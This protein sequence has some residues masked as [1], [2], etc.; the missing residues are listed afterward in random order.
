MSEPI[1]LISA[2][3]LKALCGAKMGDPGFGS[4]LV[5]G[6][7]AAT[8][9]DANCEGCLQAAAPTPPPSPRPVREGETLGR[10]GRVGPKGGPV[11]VERARDM[12]PEDHR[13]A[14]VEVVGF[15]DPRLI[16]TSQ[17][18][19]AD[20]KGA[21]L[22]VVGVDDHRG[23]QHLD[24]KGEP[25]PSEAWERANSDLRAGRFDSEREAMTRDLRR[26]REATP[27]PQRLEHVMQ[28]VLRL[29]STR[30]AQIRETDAKSGADNDATHPNGGR[31]GDLAHLAPH[32][33]D[34]H[35]LSIRLHVEWVEDA[36]D[37]HHGRSTKS[38]VLMSSEEKDALLTGSKL[39]GLSPEEIIAVHPELGAAKTIRYVRGLA[40]Q[41]ARGLPKIDRQ[42]AA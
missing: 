31:H 10:A 23:L 28:E 17:P 4:A 19:L 27:L 1:H 2:T 7:G 29:Q 32:E 21:P 3:T 40:G 12:S 30:A 15:E 33:L 5:H 25:R 26:T 8:T 22:P 13:R 16:I 35:L 24:G 18:P 38:Y 37:V 6:L 34:R 36:L 9:A 11:K 14:T 39:R 42:A 41:D 20:E